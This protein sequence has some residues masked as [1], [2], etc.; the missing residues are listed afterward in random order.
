MTTYR[1]TL[2]DAATAVVSVA[3][4]ALAVWVALAGP[5]GPIPMHFGADS[6]PDRWG[7]RNELAG[8]LGLMA[9]LGAG[10]GA[11]MGWYAAKAD[12]PARRRGLRFGQG[13]S[14]L[15]VGGSAAFMC[16]SIL[17]HVSNGQ[18]LDAGWTIAGV[19]VLLAVIGAGM[20]RVAPNPFV[21]VRTPWTYKS[22]LAWDRSN[23]LAGRLMFWLGLTFMVL[24]P[25]A[26]QPWG[27][28]GLIAGVFV[29][30]GWSVLESWRVWRTDP[31]RQPF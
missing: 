1:F 27:S 8:A 6:Q 2:L 23:R 9:V 20:G 25:V 21:G 18:P 29:A 12:D 16:A 7:D 4:L 11:G 15:A 19:G 5:T 14:I 13:V 31:D 28:Y 26:P 3:I 22:R 24:G 10:L 30:L 17:G